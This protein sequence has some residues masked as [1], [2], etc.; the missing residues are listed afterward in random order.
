MWVWKGQGWQPK[1][2]KLPCF[3]GIHFKLFF[4][5]Q[6]TQTGMPSS[7]QITMTMNKVVH[8]CLHSLHLVD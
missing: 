6:V 7:I 4:S 5:S 2:T 8:D 3:E 1:E